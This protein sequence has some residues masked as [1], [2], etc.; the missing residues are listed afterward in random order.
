[1]YTQEHLAA[2]VGSMHPLSWHRSWVSVCRLLSD[3]IFPAFHLI[4]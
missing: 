3:S 1:M 2:A 4:I